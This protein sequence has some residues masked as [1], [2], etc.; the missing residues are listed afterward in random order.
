MARPLPDLPQ[1]RRCHHGSRSV[2]GARKY[3]VRAAF[4][5]FGRFLPRLSRTFGSGLFLPL[6]T[7]HVLP[8]PL[9][10]APSLAQGGAG[11]TV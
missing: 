3:C 1:G 7:I 8:F 5:P 11:R 10:Q 6:R 9:L 2:E 4:S